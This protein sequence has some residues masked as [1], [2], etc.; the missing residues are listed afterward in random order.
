VREAIRDALAGISSDSAAV[1]TKD[2][3]LA[4]VFFDSDEAYLV[5]VQQAGLMVLRG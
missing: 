1:N 3:G 5:T 2:G 4:V